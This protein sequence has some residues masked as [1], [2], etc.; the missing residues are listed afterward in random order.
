MS[1]NVN[2]SSRLDSSDQRAMLTVYTKKEVTFI[3]FSL[4][5]ITMA[6]PTLITRKRRKKELDDKFSKRRF[7]LPMPFLGEVRGE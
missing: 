6:S 4:K 5:N 7:D 2:E 1:M 3:Q